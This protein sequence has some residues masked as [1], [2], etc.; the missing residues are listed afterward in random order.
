[1][2]ELLELFDKLIVKDNIKDN[3]NV[4][5][6]DTKTKKTKNNIFGLLK[7][8]NQILKRKLNTK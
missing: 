7:K 5:S 3:V 1:M 4:A 6:S 8:M 2:E